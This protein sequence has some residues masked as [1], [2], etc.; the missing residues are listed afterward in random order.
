MK[1]R[2]FL[3]MVLAA[4]TMV[5]DAQTPKADSLLE[6]LKRDTMNYK[7]LWELCH[8]FVDRD[9]PRSLLY[10]K[11]CEKIAYSK[12]DTL[13][14]VQSSRLVGQLYNRLTEVNLAIEALSEA[15][16]IA[17]RHGFR[18]EIK[19]I[20]NSLAI[21]FTSK[22]EYDRA[23]DYLFKSMK[24]KEE[25]GDIAGVSVALHNI[26][27]IYHSIKD[28]RLALDNWRRSLEL[29]RKIGE[30]YDLDAIYLNLGICQFELKEF[31]TAQI[32]LD[33]VFA[34]CRPNCRPYIILMA[35]LA[36]GTLFLREKKLKQAKDHLIVSLELSRNENNSEGKMSS[37]NKLSEIAMAEGDFQ[38][39][40]R[41]L[42]EAYA[43]SGKEQYVEPFRDL[44]KLNANYFLEIGDYKM[45]SLFERKYSQLTDSVNDFEMRRRLMEIQIRFVERENRE[46][47]QNQQALLAAQ[48]KSIQ[49]QRIINLLLGG[50]AILTVCLL[51][52]YYRLNLKKTLINKRLN[53][54]VEER[55]A[56]LVQ[57]RLELQHAYNEQSIVL[58]KVSKNLGDTLATIRGLS[59]VALLETHKEVPEFLR[60]TE[61]KLTLLVES[62]QR[63]RALS[64]SQER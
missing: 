39:V 21:S 33:S 55:T 6:V 32:Y 46:K 9:N 37:L 19:K 2:Y 51:V 42:D 49:K 52:V 10:A 34:A 56:E 47:L 41:Y 31:Q 30:R 59:H 18:D 22:G 16:L 45:A 3:V 1:K 62:T 5:A 24:M 17:E 27:G 20:Q 4:A 38:S 44:C 40:K 57:N 64:L 43:I 29:K 25:D 28:N 36:Q 13:L 7:V 54:L 58:E 63:L 8:D 53:I 11:R 12:R 23:L 50:I 60:I 61:N 15:L 48:T 14:I 35:E 26:G